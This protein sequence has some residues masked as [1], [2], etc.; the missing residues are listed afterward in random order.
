MSSDGLKSLKGCLRRITEAGWPTDPSIDSDGESD[1]LER[2][3]QPLF[4]IFFQCG[5]IF[6]LSVRALFIATACLTFMQFQIFMAQSFPALP[7]TP[8]AGH[9][10]A[11]PEHYSFT[12]PPLLSAASQIYPFIRRVFH[13]FFSDVVLLT[14]KKA[15]GGHTSSYG[16][17]GG[18]GGGSC[19][20]IAHCGY[21]EPQCITTA[22]SLIGKVS[23][24]Q[25]GGHD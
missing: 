22:V 12:F 18:G 15:G 21:S 7:Q 20:P 8:G 4:S 5:S 17:G 1:N 14:F 13:R 19:G 9:S 24:F 10:A 6:L 23:P 16:G 2:R 3:Q 25:E 11:S